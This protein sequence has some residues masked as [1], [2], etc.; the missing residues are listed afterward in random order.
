[1]IAI[2]PLVALVH[3]PPCGAVLAMTFAS[4]DKN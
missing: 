3:V 1:M 4:A 2:G